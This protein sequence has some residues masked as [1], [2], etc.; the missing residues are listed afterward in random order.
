MGR[1][2]YWKG[3]SNTRRSDNA[4]SFGKSYKTT[5]SRHGNRSSGYGSSPAK[6]QKAASDRYHGGKKGGC[7]ITSA[8]V[9]ARGLSDNCTELM[10][11]REFRDNYLA[12]QENGS[13]M[14]RSYYDF[15]PKIVASIDSS[16]NARQVYDELYQNLVQKCVGL[17]Q[18]GD[19][20][21]ALRNYEQV[22]QNLKQKYI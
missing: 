20:K 14:I 2:N 22:F 13:E 10:T 7:Y 6:S 5:I 1:K 15:A 16:N 17:I 12:G 9:D 11:L 3:T 21:G 18:K 19:N 4:F 8:C